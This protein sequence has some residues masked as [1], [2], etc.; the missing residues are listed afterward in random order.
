MSFSSLTVDIPS[1]DTFIHPEGPL[2]P[3]WNHV[4]EEN[5]SQDAPAPT[6]T[7]IRWYNITVF[8]RNLG[9]VCKVRIG[10]PPL[11]PS[12]FVQN[13]HIPQL[14]VSTIPPLT[15]ESSSHFPKPKKAPIIPAGASTQEMLCRR[16]NRS[17]WEK[18]DTVLDTYGFA[19]LGDFLSTL[20]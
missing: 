12:I 4:M 13:A 8:Q 17:K 7:K 16:D 15:S 6:V 9:R 3:C 5:P 18:M 20:F 19:N 11:T 2:E 1:K 10:R 14:T